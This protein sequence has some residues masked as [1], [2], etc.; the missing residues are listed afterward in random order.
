MQNLFAKNIA[1]FALDDI[2]VILEFTGS[3]AVAEIADC[4]TH[5]AVINYHLDNN[6]PLCS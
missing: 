3:P 1:Q 6:T 2:E 4:S 5:D